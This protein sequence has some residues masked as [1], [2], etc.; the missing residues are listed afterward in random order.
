MKN[1]FSTNK[2]ENID[3]ATQKIHISTINIFCIACRVYSKQLTSVKEQMKE[4]ESVRKMKAMYVTDAK[5]VI[6]KQ[7]RAAHFEHIYLL[8]YIAYLCKLALD[9]YVMILYVFHFQE[10]F[11]CKICNKMF[12]NAT[13]RV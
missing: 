2:S 1:S 6:C 3:N 12:N 11:M 7:H 4:A 9:K 13:N 8:F 10:E 5:S